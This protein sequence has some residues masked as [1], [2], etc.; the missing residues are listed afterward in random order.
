MLR[1]PRGRRWAPLIVCSSPAAY[2]NYDFPCLHI[3]GK[4]ARFLSRIQILSHCFP[5]VFA[6]SKATTPT[7]KVESDYKRWKNFSILQSRNLPQIIYFIEG[8]I[9]HIVN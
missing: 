8:E 3:T 6:L 9:S 5:L 4:C 1:I 2:V 7:T